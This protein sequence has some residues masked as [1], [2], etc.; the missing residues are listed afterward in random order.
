MNK[1]NKIL[2]YVLISTFTGGYLASI[3]SFAKNQSL[4]IL[5]NKDIAESGYESFNSIIQTKDGGF[6]V[7]GEVD[8][9][10]EQAVSRG[11]AIIIKYDSNG[12]KQWQ[13]TIEGDDT[14]LFYDVVESRNGDF[15]VI[16]KSFSTDVFDNPDGYSNAIVV[17]YD[18]NG[19]EVAVKAI[20]DNG[21][22][23]NYNSIIEFEDNKFILVGEKNNNGVR[24]GFLTTFELTGDNA[25]YNF[26]AIEDNSRQ[27][28]IKEVIKTSEN[29]LVVI[30]SSLENGVSYPYISML[31]TNGNKE[32]SY[33]TYSDLNNNILNTRGAFTTIVED[34]NGNL[35]VGGYSLDSES[36]A[37]MMVFN[38]SG[39]LINNIKNVNAELKSYSS[40]LIN[41][42]NEILAIGQAKLLDK[43]S[44]LDNSKIII[45]NYS[46]NY[47]KKS[48][49][50]LYPALK[51][52]LSNDA[53]ITSSD[54][55]I[56][57]GESF[58]KVETTESKCKVT[59]VDMPDECIH[60]DASI[61]KV[62]YKEA[63]VC[64]ITDKPE[65]KAENVVAYKGEKFEPL[66]NVT[67]VDAEKNDITSKIE[68]VSNNVNIEKEGEYTVKY[69]VEDKCGNISEKEI[70]VTITEKKV[71]SATDEVVD[72]TPSKTEKPQTGDN[73]LAYASLSLVS[74]L[75][76]LKSKNKNK[77]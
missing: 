16:G 18:S 28:E 41:S 8:L 12:K 38:K 7:V 59:P 14:D 77:K 23:I 15:Y 24:T 53:I 47:S 43:Q 3:N 63:E 11:D 70:K 36:N 61:L 46:V 4:E 20:H 74:S 21:K 65:I 42:K 2:S 57:A 26:I 54:E 17:K 34:K 35:I 22:Q 40:V 5:W 9:K 73:I 72:K 13:N 76:L 30:G 75:S 62:K 50:S 32:W 10:G 68:V 51:N 1:K 6:V 67:A 56:L 39:Q 25:S 58:N 60:S 66:K 49:D 19:N 45:D 71:E 27:T 52:V 69:K 48:S 64:T 55:I 33:S 37:L 44:V 31:D 29:K